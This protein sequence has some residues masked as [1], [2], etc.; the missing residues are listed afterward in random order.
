MLKHSIIKAAPLGT[1]MALSLSHAVVHAAP[2]PLIYF[3]MGQRG[4]APVTTI[5]NK[6][7]MTSVTAS[8]MSNPIDIFAGAPALGDFDAGT[9]GYARLA[10]KP[11]TLSAGSPNLNLTSAVTV[12]AWIRWTVDPTTGNT[13]AVIVSQQ[14]KT[15]GSEDAPFSLRMDS[16]TP[17]KFVFAVQAANGN[18]SVTSVTGAL[19][20]QWYH[21]T[22]VYNGTGVSI[23]VNGL[24]EKTTSWTGG[25][26]KSITNNT[27]YVLQIGRYAHSFVRPVYGDID[28]VR[29][30]NAALSES[31]VAGLASTRI[32][33]G[34]SVDVTE[35]TLTVS[36]HKSGSSVSDSGFILSGKI[37]DNLEEQ[38]VEV[39]V[40]DP[41][42]KRVLSYNP[43]TVLYP[44]GEWS[45]FVAGSQLTSGRTISVTVDALDGDFNMTSQSLSLYVRPN[46]ALVQHLSNRISFGLPLGEQDRLIGIGYNDVLASQLNPGSLEGTALERQLSALTVNTLSTLQEYELRHMLYSPWYLQEVLAWFWTNHFNTQYSAISGA[47]PTTDLV[48]KTIAAQKADNDGYRANAL[49]NFEELLRLSAHSPAMMRYLNNN[50]NVVGRPNENYARELMELHT[51]GVNGGY[52]QTKDVEEVAR[53]LTGW[54]HDSN[55]Q[56]V[57]NSSKHDTGNKLVMGKTI[58]GRTGADGKFEGDELLHQLATHAGT[59]R[60]ICTKLAQLLV[61]DAPLTDTLDECQTVFLAE[62]DSVDQLAVVVE[63]LLTSAEMLDLNGVHSKVRSPLEF[64]PGLIHHGLVSFDMSSL[65]S[66][67][68]NMGAPMFNFAPPT[69]LP[70]VRQGWLNTYQQAERQNLANTL[71]WKSVMGNST[72][73]ANVQAY[74]DNP[75]VTADDLLD[76]VLERW[77]HGDYSVQEEA[78]LAS[79]LDTDS[80][81]VVA[82]DI[83]AASAAQVLKRFLGTALSYPTALYQ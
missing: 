69:G 2:A 20:D 67:P 83:E 58:V 37:S 27:D 25:N 60:F 71:L 18:K 19:K 8:A 47:N 36:S 14:N 29:I 66:E 54:S 51:L 21:V 64:I 3:D 31:E 13:N 38:R 30:Y 28:E 22:G 26:L 59:A 16:G 65:R 75:G 53:V 73:Q 43:V 11:Y 52:D 78:F 70:E 34:H 80:T 5:P 68:T 45:L 56:F 63:T 1:L 81:S 24:H 82:F 46:N 15:T 10:G 48:R 23:Y 12:S 72:H 62:S 76:F 6:G 35:P 17:R 77:Y 57:F 40:Y 44:S 74:L 55:W 33:C 4:S 61:S 41:V 9:C 49:G 42:L 7:S 79:L 50:T 32:G 39:T